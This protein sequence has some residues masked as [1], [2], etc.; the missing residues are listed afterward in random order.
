MVAPLPP[1]APPSRFGRGPPR[2]A[3]LLGLGAARLTPHNGRGCVRA[4]KPMRARRRRRTSRGSGCL[5]WPAPGR[6]DPRAS[7]SAYPSVLPLSSTGRRRGG[8]LAVTVARLPDL[9]PVMMDD[10][11]G[12]GRRCDRR[13]AALPGPVPAALRA[14]AC[15]RAAASWTD[16]AQDVVAETFLVAWRHIRKAPA[17]PLASTD[18]SVPAGA[19]VASLRHPESPAPGRA[20]RGRR[21]Q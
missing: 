13:R 16:R 15:L 19:V 6:R 2:G 10:W 9:D 7:V 5:T 12:R 11:L 8:R 21:I 3:V 17:D 20:G 1:P 14:S 18:G 4:C